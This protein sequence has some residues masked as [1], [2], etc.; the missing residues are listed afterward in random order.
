M[1]TFKIR[2]SVVFN[3]KHPKGSPE[4]KVFLDAARKLSAIKG[5]HRFECLLQVS[6][7]NNYDYAL[8]MEFDSQEAYDAYNRDPAHDA[9]VKTFWVQNVKEFLELDFE[10]MK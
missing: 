9:F 2:H 5:V 4:E 10:I 3:L 8:S 6:R 1:N 7:K